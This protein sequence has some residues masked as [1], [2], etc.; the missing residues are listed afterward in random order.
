MTNPVFND[1]TDF[2]RWQVEQTLTQVI[3]KLP[4]SRL[5]QAMGYSLL[6][7]GKRVRAILVYGAN[8][9]L[10]DITPATDCA[11]A[12]IECIHAYS[13]IHDDLPAMDNDELRRGKATCH[14]AFDEATAILAGDSLQALGFELISDSDHI[15]NDRKVAMISALAQASG[16]CGMV[17]G[18]AQDLEAVN[19]NINIFELEHMHRLKTGALMNCAITLGV[20][21]SDSTDQQKNLAL[22]E[23]GNA[24]GLAFQVQDDILDV[25]SDTRTLGKTQGADQA[26]NKPT[27]VSILGLQGAQQ[28][29]QELYQNAMDALACFDHKAD[30]LRHLATYI[31]H[32]TH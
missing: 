22:R 15:S 3:S 2:C 1:F 29:A 16:A 30:H 9:A 4:S 20:L 27:Y 7:G 6:E 14:I 28:K 31:V 24:L 10:D 25:T 26:L 5:T 12:A 21:A 13:L 18:Q 32:R 11:A 8:A 19:K 23:Y 17:A